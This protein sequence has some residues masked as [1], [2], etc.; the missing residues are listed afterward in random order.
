LFFVQTLQ[1][2]IANNWIIL[3][4]S[5]APKKKENETPTDF[6]EK[7]AVLLFITM[8]TFLRDVYLSIWMNKKKKHTHTQY[9]SKKSFFF[10]FKKK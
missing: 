8:I 2:R 7:P 6:N 5:I 10:Q 3:I 1:L 4:D 9:L